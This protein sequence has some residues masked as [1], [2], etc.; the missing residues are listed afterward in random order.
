MNDVS[1]FISDRAW[2]LDELDLE[3]G[4][5]RFLKIDRARLEE[6]PFLDERLDRSELESADM[7]LT[8]LAAVS[9]VPLGGE[10]VFIW[11]SAFC[12]S[13]LL[14]RCLSAPG[15]AL[16]L[17]EPA[18]LM[19]LA[20]LKRHGHSHALDRLAGP[21]LGLLARLAGEG[22]QAIIKPTNIANNLVTDVARIFPRARHLF[23]TSD[24][25]AFLVSIAKKKEPGR[26]LAR[27][28]FSLLQYDG[29]S[30][31]SIPRDQLFALTDLQVAALVWHMQIWQMHVAQSRLGPERSAWLDGDTFLARP[32]EALEAVNRFFELG[33]TR[34][35][36]ETVASGPLMARDAKDPG[37]AFGTQARRQEAR[38]VLEN[39]GD[40][41]PRIIDWSFENVPS[42]RRFAYLSY[43]LLEV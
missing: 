4:R 17:R 36:I 39:L 21:V 20:S 35:E 1:T 27:R 12:G 24:I 15:R 29:A 37:R 33:H 30:P 42:S 28:M 22:E 11:H 14:A 25:E 23:L 6:A 41:L 18:V 3:A 8:E 32:V 2:F 26:A 43:P 34:E 40:D 31:V 19:T 10:P 16:A 9:S 7:T 13:T 38:A 5:A